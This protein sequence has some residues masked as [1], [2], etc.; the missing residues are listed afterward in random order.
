M[1]WVLAKCGGY[2]VPDR[3]CL[4]EPEEI[5]KEWICARNSGWEGLWERGKGTLGPHWIRG[6]GWAGR[7][8]LSL[9]VFISQLWV[10]ASTNPV[11]LNK[12]SGNCITLFSIKSSL[13]LKAPDANQMPTFSDLRVV[14]VPRSRLEEQWRAHRTDPQKAQLTFTGFVLFLPPSQKPNVQFFCLWW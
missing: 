1:L 2:G 13:A 6:W 4:Y 7:R 14:R 5:T 12:V 8:D 11:R 10:V 3:E 9:C